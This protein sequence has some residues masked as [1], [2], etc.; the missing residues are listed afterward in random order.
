MCLSRKYLD[1]ISCTICMYNHADTFFYGNIA[2][3]VD[4]QVVSHMAHKPHAS[5]NHSLEAALN[6]CRVVSQN[7]LVAGY[8][9]ITYLNQVRTTPAMSHNSLSDCT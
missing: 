4:C 3:V 6:C 2:N 1:P 8:D 5:W 7:I 9:G